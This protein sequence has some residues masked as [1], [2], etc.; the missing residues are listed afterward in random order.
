[1][2]LKPLVRPQSVS[3]SPSLS[4]FDEHPE[5]DADYDPD[6]DPD[7]DKIGKADTVRNQ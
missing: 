3:G 5:S 1:M 4:E 7:P 2:R 6:I